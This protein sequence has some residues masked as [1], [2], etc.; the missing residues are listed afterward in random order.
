MLRVNQLNFKDAVPPATNPILV[1][2]PTAGEADKERAGAETVETGDAAGG[3]IDYTPRF[4]F[5]P[6]SGKKILARVVEKCGDRG[7]FENWAREVAEIAKSRIGQIKEKLA[8]PAPEQKKAFDQFPAYIGKLEKWEF[9]TELTSPILTTYLWKTTI[10][11][12]D[13]KGAEIML[14]M[15]FH[16]SVAKQNGRY[17]IVGSWFK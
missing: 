7:Y 14:D 12:K 13:Q 11:R 6:Q 4:A 8:D 9:L 1:G 17:V 5:D 10:R 16:L 15:L 2:G 3:D